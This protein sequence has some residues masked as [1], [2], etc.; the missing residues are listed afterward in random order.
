MMNKRTA[1]KSALL[2][3]V[4]LTGATTT[5]YAGS[6]IFTKGDLV[7]DTVTGS[8]L[9]TASPIT[10]K[11]FSLGS[12]GAS[13][14]PVWSL[15]LPQIANGANA[16]ISGEYGSASEGLMQLTG[17]GDFLTLLGYGVNAN[18]FNTAPLSTYGTAALGQTTSLTGQPYTTVPRVVALISGK[19]VVNTTTA[20]TGVFNTNNPRSVYSATG[21]SFYVSGQG[22][23]KTDSTQGVFYTTLGSTTATPIDTSTDTRFVTEY[24]GTLY[25]SRDQNPPGSGNQNYSNVSSL[26]GPKGQPPLNSTGLVTTH[27]TPPASPYS[28]GGNNG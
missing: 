10:L 28:S 24:N 13:A 5:A 14:N 9:D 26:T 8:V 16:P 21:Y 22:A 4:A 18:T 27:I 6:T 12:G 20:L 7:I 1:L 15:T 23:S 3:S 2:V 11:E 25:V 17:N 19:G